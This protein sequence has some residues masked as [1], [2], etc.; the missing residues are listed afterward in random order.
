MLALE[1]RQYKDAN[2]E[3]QTLVPVLVG[4]T[5]AARQGKWADEQHPPLAVT[6]G[7]APGAGVKVAADGVVTLFTIFPGYNAGS[8]EMPF[9]AFA[10]TPPFDRPEARREIQRRLNEILPDA[11]VGDDKL[12]KYPSLAVPVLA[13]PSA[14]EAFVAT[15]GWILG[16]ATDSQAEG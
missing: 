7:S 9:A 2:Q 5:Q 16:Q 15:I 6:F 11:R 3:H 10:K 12:E 14:F 13:E 1:I 8:V 4:E